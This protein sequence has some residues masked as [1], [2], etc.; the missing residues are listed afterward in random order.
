MAF[1]EPPDVLRT[2]VID[3]VNQRLPGAADLARL[4]FQFTL[5]NQ[6]GNGCSNPGF[7]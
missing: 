1:A 6:F 4:L 2:G 7:I 3:V 5:T